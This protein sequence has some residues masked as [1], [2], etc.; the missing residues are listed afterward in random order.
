MDANTSLKMK[1]DFCK[2]FGNKVT[3]TYT[4]QAIFGRRNIKSL[5]ESCNDS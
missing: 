2:V 4:Y 1:K 5:T 3:Q